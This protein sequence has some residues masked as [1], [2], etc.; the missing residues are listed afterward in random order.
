MQQLTDKFK[1]YLINHPINEI[2]EVELKKLH[3]L[4]SLSY[5]VREKITNELKRRTL[6]PIKNSLNDEQI[7][8]INNYFSTC[9]I[10]NEK[11]LVFEMNEI[12]FV[13]LL[14]K[15]CYDLD[16]EEYYLFDIKLYFPELYVRVIDNYLIYKNFSG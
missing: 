12:D 5:D 15:N 6:E 4:K 8:F 9:Y 3:L 10:K 16:E 2:N 11:N 13:K 1:N 7:N 14:T